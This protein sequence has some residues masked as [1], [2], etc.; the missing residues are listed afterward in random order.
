MKKNL[1]KA[2]ALLAVALALGGTPVRAGD[3]ELSSDYEQAEPVET[4]ESVAAKYAA[5]T[6]QA[7]EANEAMDATVLEQPAPACPSCGSSAGCRCSN[8]CPPVSDKCPRFGSYFWSGVDSWRGVSDGT[9]Q[10]NDGVVTGANVAA[11]L[12][13]LSEYGFGAQAGASYGVYD[14]DGRASSAPTNLAQQ[15]VFV[16]TGLFRRADASLP[17]GRISGGVVYDWQFNNNFGTFANSPTLGQWRGQ[18]AYAFSAWNE[19][20]F[21]GAIRDRGAQKITP[22]GLQEYSAINQGNLFWHHKY[23]RWGADS[24][25]YI[26]I[27]NQHRLN[28]D[29]ANFGPAG[30][31][32][33]LG[34][35]IVGTNWNVPINDRLDM[36]ANAMYMRPSAHAG[37][38]TGPLG[39]G[40]G[41]AYASAQ[42]FWNISFGLTYYPGR[43][44]RSSTVAG[45]KWMP[46]LPVANNG[47]FLVDTNL[48]Q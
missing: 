38:T 34:T 31:G 18:I 8:W 7:F 4:Q 46:Y 16:T 5:D 9:F 21:W 27:P 33:S 1:F 25:F 35:F 14:F 12:A 30:A 17:L 41:T 32:G 37:A 43:A 13:W 28:Q 11:P 48:T 36:Y 44:A 19:I 22:L 47:T 3:V 45:R 6:D 39:P 26:G 23:Q 10:N 24:R 20:G 42:D 29:F 40:A 15:Q 2:G